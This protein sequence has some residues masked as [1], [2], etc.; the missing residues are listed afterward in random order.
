MVFLTDEDV[1]IP[2][3]NRASAEFLG[4]NP[5]AVLRRLCGEARFTMPQ[6]AVPRSM[7]FNHLYHHRGQLTAH[8]RLKDLP[9]PALYGPSADEECM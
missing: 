2:G 9:V 5:E 6:S 7:I 1:R 3:H 8:L 4:P